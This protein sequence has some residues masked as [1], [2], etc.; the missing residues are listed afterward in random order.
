MTNK[1][2][3]DDWLS[4]DHLLTIEKISAA[5][6]GNGIEYHNVRYCDGINRRKIANSESIK[7][8]LDLLI[9][10]EESIN[11]SYD[12]FEDDYDEDPRALE[13]PLY[14]YGWFRSELPDFSMI[15]PNDD[16]SKH[17]NNLTHSNTF[18]TSLNS[19]SNS[20]SSIFSNYNG[21]RPNQISFV[22]LNNDTAKVVIKGK[23]IAVSST[24]FNLAVKSQ[25]W[26]LIQSACMNSGDLTQGL[27]QL[28][29]K[30]D[31]VKNHQIV[32][33]AISRLSSKLLKSMGLE[34]N[35]IVLNGGYQFIFKSMTHEMLDGP[36]S[37]KQDAMDYTSN[38]DVDDYDLDDKDDFDD[39]DDF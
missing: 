28:N 34:S 10:R 15:N 8:A 18:K 27:K 4:I 35:P 26:K 14:Q 21:L 16:V 9:A 2:D 1:Y 38:T 39:R 23:T 20:L 3:P 5:K 24:D 13:S 30:T 33:T 6:I 11:N 12:I 25:G 36:S 32:T 17:S 31:Q 22:M 29:K 7:I 37:L 19:E